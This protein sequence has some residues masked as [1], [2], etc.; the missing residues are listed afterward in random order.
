VNIVT[1]VASQISFSALEEKSQPVDSSSDDEDEFCQF[2]DSYIHLVDDADQ[3]ALH[4]EEPL[5]FPVVDL[6]NIDE[7]KFGIPVA[8]HISFGASK[9]K[10]QRDSS[11]D[12]E[13]EFCQFI[14]SHIHLVDG[15]DQ[16]HD[17]LN[18]EEFS[19]IT[20]VDLVNMDESMDHCSLA[21]EYHRRWCNLHKFKC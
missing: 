21:A 3:A 4:L 19:P 20:V 9:E 17:A 1:P 18:L 16:M 14:D 15:A 10:S 12:N 7:S 2:I 11:S 13:D 8:S 6:V 5:P